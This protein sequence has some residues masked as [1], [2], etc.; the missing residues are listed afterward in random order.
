MKGTFFKMSIR[1]NNKRSK[2]THNNDTLNM[3]HSL[4][5]L[6]ISLAKHSTAKRHDLNI[7]PFE[8]DILVISNRS[9]YSRLAFPVLLVLSVVQNWDLFGIEEGP[10][11]VSQKRF[12]SHL[13]F[14]KKPKKVAAA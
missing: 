3:N 14:Y 2:K 11:P 6:K 4:F 7:F 8:K 12:E 13:P 5:L 1:P 10:A 9:Y